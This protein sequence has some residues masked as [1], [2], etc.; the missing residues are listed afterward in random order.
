MES[1]NQ[2]AN[3]TY[4]TYRRA[5][6][7]RRL[8][9]AFCDLDLF[10]RNAAALVERADGKPIR[11]ASKSV[12]VQALLERT[13]AMDGFEG[14]LCYSALEAAHLAERGFRDL[15]VAYPTVDPHDIAAVC[16]ALA[17]T[18]P[19]GTDPNGTGS[20]AGAVITLMVDAPEQV[21]RLEA[22][23]AAHGIV[24]PLCLDLDV[25]SSF[26][27][28]H[29]G[30]R[31]SPLRHADGALALARHIAGQDHLEL[32][33][34]MGYEAQIAGIPD[35]APGKALNPVIRWLKGRSMP[36]VVRRR[37]A[38]VDHLRAE[39]FEL[40]FV[41]GGGTGSLEATA[42]DPSVTELTAGSGLYS[43]GLFDGF[44]DFQHAPA[45]GFAL[46]VT[47]RPAPG[48]VTCHGG[49]YVA[50]GEPGWDKVPSPYLP[51]GSK[52]LPHEAAG[53]VQTPIQLPAGVDLDLGDPVLFR[54]AKAGEL[55]EHFP[56]L[57]LVSGGEVVDEVSTYRGEGWCFL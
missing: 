36:E 37:C 41:N 39:G 45:A 52:L 16:G 34:L 30:V 42:A 48:L 13:L 21:D 38:A 1:T 15:V 26:P 51:S 6:E 22:L 23:A 49:G 29:F 8:P 9:L 7:G 11:V 20:D 5:F 17:G 56:S 4:A 47:R 54:H 28:L 19:N 3:P 35:A 46:P 33:G 53:E 2:R 32:R 50:S 57:L 14:L 40:D 25:S 27:G 18:D 55:C 44:R 24:L 12:R 43:P 31:R 10:D